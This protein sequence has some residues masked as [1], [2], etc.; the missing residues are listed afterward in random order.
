MTEDI[1]TLSRKFS[2]VEIAVI[3][4][5]PSPSDPVHEKGGKT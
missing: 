3:L 5:K 4:G 1:I 2:K